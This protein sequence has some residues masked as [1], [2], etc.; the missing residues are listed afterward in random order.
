MKEENNMSQK[1]IK[2]TPRLSE[3][4]RNRR[5]ELGLTIEEAASRAG[6]GIKTW[7]RYEAGESIRKDKSKGICKALNWRT[8]PDEAIDEENG[9]DINEYKKHEAWSQYICDRY[10]EAAAIS[11]VVGSDVL[12]DDLEE[13][14]QELSS[15]PKGT[16]VGQLAVS[17]M[18]DILP[19]QFL[20]RY[21]YEFLYCLKTNVDTLR[22]IAHCN[23]SLVVHTVLQELAIYLF[24][25]EAEFLIE[26]MSQ[27]MEAYGIKELDTWRDWIYDLFNDM[28]IVACLYSGNYL[29]CDHMYHFEHWTEEQFYT[30]TT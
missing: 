18:K 16:H 1:V 22:K 19:E 3:A 20:M 28:D 11:F 12:L 15:K 25:E 27:D 26:C 6:V 13:D 23:T 4:I 14:L 24:V 7:C 5:Q 21:D 29:T 10:G 17:R 9:F 2:G 30:R 8:V